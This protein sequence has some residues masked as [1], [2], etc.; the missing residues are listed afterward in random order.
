M[1]TIGSTL[2]AGSTFAPAGSVCP[3]LSS[4]CEGPLLASG[5]RASARIPV[6]DTHNARNAKP[7]QLPDSI[8]LINVVSTPYWMFCLAPRNPQLASESSTDVRDYT[9]TNHPHHNEKYR[10]RFAHG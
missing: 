4:T 1:L 10:F 5:G 7:L 8:H 9:V 6:V 2:P 3:A